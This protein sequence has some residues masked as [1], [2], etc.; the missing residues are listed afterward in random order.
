MSPILGP[1]A[2]GP[3]ADY[4][5]VPAVGS[6]GAELQVPMSIHDHKG[7]ARRT[8]G[9]LQKCIAHVV[10]VFA[11]CSDRNARF[12]ISNAYGRDHESTQG[13]ATTSP[14]EEV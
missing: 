11:W 2:I 10:G 6:V 8:L 13:E 4:P 12:A 5:G 14:T 3:V 1:T 7:S 9:E